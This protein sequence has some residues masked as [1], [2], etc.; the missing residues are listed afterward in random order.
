MTIS[1]MPLPYAHDALAPHI[2]A[3]T[4]HVHHGAH[5]KTYVDKV[6]AAIAGTEL[7]DKPIEEIIAASKAQGTRPLYNS[8]AQTWN[9]GFYWNS[10]APEISR[11]AE[12]LLAAIN[13]AF[14]GLDELLAK[15][16]DEAVN[17]FASGWAWL[18]ANGDTVQ[19]ISTHDAEAP[20]LDGQNPLLTIDVW[21]HA[22]YIDVKNKRPDYV[23]SVTGNLLNWEFASENFSRGTPW[24]YP[25]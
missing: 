11:P 2:S 25:S 10:M 17:H 5:H 7:A 16:K 18:I 8:A 21:E 1:L 9:H 6:N 23:T 20:I 4:L 3:D 15:L 24:S 19:V 12:P 22:Y 14:G 13:S